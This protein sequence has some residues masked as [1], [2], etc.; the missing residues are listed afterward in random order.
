MRRVV[1]TIVSLMVA[2]L[3]FVSLSTKAQISIGDDLSK[4]NYERPAEYTIGGIEDGISNFSSRC[5][6]N[7]NLKYD[8][9]TY[10][11]VLA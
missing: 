10:S 2:G 7:I 8:A 1:R 6:F 3:V 11:E 9:I 4:I 5:F